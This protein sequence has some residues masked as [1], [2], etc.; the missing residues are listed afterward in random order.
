MQSVLI[1]FNFVVKV[2]PVLS[3]PKRRAL[4]GDD[5]RVSVSS[6]VFFSILLWNNGHVRSTYY[7]WTL[8]RIP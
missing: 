3:G 7:N 5:P 8:A 4:S 1:E 6:T 2:K